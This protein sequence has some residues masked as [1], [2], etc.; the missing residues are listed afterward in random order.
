MSW[1][2]IGIP[3]QAKI[4]FVAAVTALIFLAGFKTS[5]FISDAQIETINAGWNK[6]LSAAKD[7][8]LAAEMVSRS[9]ERKAAEEIA[10]SAA[11]FEKV[12]QDEKATSDRYVT[13]LR[14]DVT[15]LRVTVT[16]LSRP[17]VVPGT[18]AAASGGDGQSEETLNGSVAARLAQRY[19]DYN[20]LVGRLD[21]C[22]DTILQY[23]A[24]K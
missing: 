13:D 1:A 20:E 24:M 6:K 21:Q 14:N 23:R 10:A 11:N 18:P 12:R 5:T 9:A 16:R 7:A 15:R 3:V 2:Q 8:Q 19:A 4:I 17:V 22:Q